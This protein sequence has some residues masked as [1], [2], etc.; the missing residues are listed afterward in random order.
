MKVDGKDPPGDYVWKMEEIGTWLNGSTRIYA[1]NH[2]R[3][4]GDDAGVLK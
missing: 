4:E 3:A 1:H 2:R